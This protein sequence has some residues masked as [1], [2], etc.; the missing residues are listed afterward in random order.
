MN[1]MVKILHH[2]CVVTAGSPFLTEDPVLVIILGYQD[3]LTVSI[4]DAV[5]IQYSFS[6]G[7]YKGC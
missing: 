3:G 4:L 5:E 1:Y 6:Q 2:T 7:I